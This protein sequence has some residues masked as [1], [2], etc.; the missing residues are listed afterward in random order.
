MNLVK[1][2]CLLI[3]PRS[4][5][6]VIGGY[7]IK[8]KEL[9]KILHDN[10]KLSLVVISD[11]NP[12]E[13]ENDFYQSHSEEYKVFVF[14]K[15]KYMVN[16]AMSLLGKE[17]LQVGFFYFK[18]VQMYVNQ[19]LPSCD[20]VIGALIRAM[21]YLKKA[22]KQA[23]VFDMVDSIALNYERSY[24]NVKSLF[25]K[26]IYKIEMGRLFKF[27]EYWIKHSDVTYL[28]NWKETEYWS[29]FGN[30]NLVPH[31][32]NSKLFSY[33]KIYEQYNNSVAFIGKMDY[34]PNVDATLWYLKNVH[35]KIGDK[36]PFYI[37]G[38]NPTKAIIDEANKFDN[39]LVTGFV[40]DPH[41]F[42]KS[43]F[44]VVAPMQTGG[45]IQNKVLEAMGLGKTVITTTLS[46]FPIHGAENNTHLIVA[47]T[48]D[49]FI[50][51]ILSLKSN[52]ERRTRIGDQARKFIMD[53]Y[54][55]EA[56]GKKYIGGIEN[57]TNKKTDDN[58][59]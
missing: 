8:N 11:H 6:P 24:P 16:A 27:E 4:I 47:D 31:G 44:A 32:V 28:F 48:P 23:I 25:W 51:E 19:V 40:E 12:D 2:K 58:S 33:D 15:Y 1:K 9:I 42:V 37:V 7:A 13:D 57:I 21:K 38:A 35:S 10:Y 26:M 49:D 50:R 18:E 3:L 52:A 30:V 22:N 29:K 39:V 41:L 56:Y 46:A 5:F 43:A 54:T 17:P 14:P 34:Q 20:I 36:V 59:K 53:N 55:W 45:G